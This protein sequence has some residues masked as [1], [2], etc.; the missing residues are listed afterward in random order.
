[1]HLNKDPKVTTPIISSA[2]AAESQFR[3]W[4]NQNSYKEILDLEGVVWRM[5]IEAELEKSNQS[6]SARGWLASIKASAFLTLD[7]LVNAGITDKNDENSIERYQYF[8]NGGKIE[9]HLKPYL[10]HGVD[11]ESIRQWL[12]QRIPEIQEKIRSSDLKEI[13]KTL[14][15]KWLDK[16]RSFGASRTP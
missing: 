3:H 10:F 15:G 12:Q 1:M 8:L 4:L 5:V 14:V 2:K 16:S 11:E 7:D 9:I 13:K 6:L